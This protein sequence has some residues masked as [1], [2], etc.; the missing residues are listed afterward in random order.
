MSDL[1]AQQTARAMVQ[2]LEGISDAD[3]AEL[4]RVAESIT[5]EQAPQLV[6]R[7][8]ELQQHIA[9]ILGEGISENG[10]FLAT[11]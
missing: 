8:A 6:Q 7:L 10:C 3:R 4:L 2:K 1:D 5:P 11:A 9:T